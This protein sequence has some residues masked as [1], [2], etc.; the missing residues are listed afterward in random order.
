MD[1]LTI[2]A[3]QLCILE[4]YSPKINIHGDEEEKRFYCYYYYCI[5]KRKYNSSSKKSYKIN[6]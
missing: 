1:R 5:N 4:N 6:E 3:A 2:L